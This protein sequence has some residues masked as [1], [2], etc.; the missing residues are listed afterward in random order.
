MNLKKY[1]D[2]ILFFEFEEQKELSLTFFRVQEY[3]ESQNDCLLNKSFSVFDFL[4]EMMCEDGYLDYFHI[5]GGFNVPGKVFNS[6]VSCIDTNHF[7]YMEHDLIN[8]VWD[9]VNIHEDFYIIGAKKGDKITLHHELAHALYHLD[10]DYRMEMSVLTSQI[11]ERYKKQYKRMKKY[12][13]KLG[14]NEKVIDDEIQAYL[15]TE[16]KKDLIADFDID[17]DSLKPLILKYK[18]ILKKSIDKFDKM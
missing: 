12:L 2:N 13:L 8:N 6:W 11:K 18:K 16:K 17:Y 1:G 9:N 5:W 7:T 4:N 10:L 14:Y 15:A 3:Y